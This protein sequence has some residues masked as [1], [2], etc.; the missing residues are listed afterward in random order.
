MVRIRLNGKY[1]K[2]RYRYALIDVFDE[3]LVRNF[4]WCA[5]KSKCGH[6]YAYSMTFGVGVLMHRLLCLPAVEV[7]HANRHTVDNRRSNLRPC[8]RSLNN[9]NAAKRQRYGGRV[10]KS[11]FKGVHHHPRGIK[12]WQA[13]LSNKS[14]GYF[15]TETEA[16]RAYD[17]AARASYGEFARC[18]FE[19]R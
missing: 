15:L 16:A 3:P 13:R 2:G 14:L 1:A 10:I 5:S 4:T 9:A 8:N 18:N 17:L 12:R 11:R 7:D 6:I 19:S